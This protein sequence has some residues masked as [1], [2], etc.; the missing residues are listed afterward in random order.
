MHPHLASVL[1]LLKDPW[2]ISWV[3]SSLATVLIPVIIWSTQRS[4]YYSAVGYALEQNQYYENNKNNNNNNANNNNNGN[5][6]STYKECGWW[7][8]ACKQKQYYYA[9]MQDNNNGEYRQKMPGWY[10][11]FGGYDNSEEMRRWKE[12]NT[13]QRAEEGNRSEGGL[14]FVYAMSLIMFFA[15][16]VF[17][18]LTVGKRQSRGMLVIL[19]GVTLFVSFMNFLMATNGAISSDDR[20]FENSYYGWYGQMGVLLAYTDFWIMLFSFGY[21]VVFQ[22][23]NYIARQKGAIELDDD[24][25]KDNNRYYSAPSA[26]V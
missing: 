15:L 8:W 2:T 21:L 26:A 23:H 17:G 3:I 9:T 5:Y 6:Y 25:D 16:V 4:N 11:I 10:I 13:G 18:V 7:N 12:E 14:K 22:V 19:L 1:V 20:D 24:D